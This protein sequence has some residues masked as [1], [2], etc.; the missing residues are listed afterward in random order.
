MRAGTVGGWHDPV[1][2]IVALAQASSFFSRI[3]P[4]VD[5]FMDETE[6]PASR[7]LRQSLEMRP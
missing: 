1:V 6:R 5:G 2:R 4:L 3:I 7:W